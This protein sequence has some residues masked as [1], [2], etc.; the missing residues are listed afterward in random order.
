MTFKIV[1]ATPVITA[2]GYSALDAVGGLLEFENVASPF[3]PALRIQAAVI[4]D[5]AK[6]SPVLN[7][8]LFDRTFTATADNDAF[9]PTDAD[10]AN[11]LGHIHWGAADYEVGSDNGVGDVSQVTLP[12]FIQLVDGGT[13]LFGQLQC[14]GTPTFASTSDLIVKLIVE[15]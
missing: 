12:H 9:D 15:T 2:G 8:F 1:T 11:C 5:K 3:Q 13:S 14:E 4:I 7:L 10:L 6:Q